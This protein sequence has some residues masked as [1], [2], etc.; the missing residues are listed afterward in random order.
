M[1]NVVK[2]KISNERDKRRQ[3]KRYLN[4]DNWGIRKDVG[5]KSSGWTAC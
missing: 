2:L 5:E 3:K 4:T 1:S